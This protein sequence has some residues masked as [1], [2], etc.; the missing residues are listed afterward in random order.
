MP[1]IL[2][3][4]TAISSMAF[5]VTILAMISMTLGD[6][7][8]PVNVWFERHGGTLM[9][10]EVISIVVLGFAAMTADRYATLASQAS[11]QPAP[12]LQPDEAVASEDSAQNGS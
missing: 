8:A 11:C 9:L 7:A 2:F 6:Q 5:V 10:L 4:L 3:Q 1:R 12:D